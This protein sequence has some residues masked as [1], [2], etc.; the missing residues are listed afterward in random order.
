MAFLLRA[1][2][3]SGME[4]MG[5]GHVRASLPTRPP[6]PPAPTRMHLGCPAVEDG[7]AR[8][9]PSQL[10][11]PGPHS[12]QGDRGRTV[13]RLWRPW[14]TGRP[15][16]HSVARG[17]KAESEGTSN[18]TVTITAR[19]KGSGSRPDPLT[20]G[21]NSSGRA[22]GPCVRSQ[23]VTWR[24]GGP[25]LLPT[26]PP[27]GTRLLAMGGRGGGGHPGGPGPTHTASLRG[28][29]SHRLPPLSA[30][31]CRQVPPPVSAALER[32][33]F[34]PPPR[35]STPRPPHLSE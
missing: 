32:R 29:R 30:V 2:F 6:T 9:H 31:G 20:S 27:S 26:T 16:G 23:G 25:P 21:R 13:W 17:G 14:L 4:L 35:L 18:I 34:S 1:T 33:C 7:R 28:P 8:R 15:A 3:R 12:G 11:Q 19:G 5:S 24:G 22:R 10:Q